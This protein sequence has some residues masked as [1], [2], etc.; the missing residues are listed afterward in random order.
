MGAL[1]SDWCRLDALGA[2]WCRLDPLDGAGRGW[3]TPVP[4][5]AV[6]AELGAGA[7]DGTAAGTP[8]CHLDS[9]APLALIFTLKGY[10][11]FKC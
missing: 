4:A 10:F 8:R 2:D 3:G 9:P 6:V 5:W 11:S 7:E 1:G